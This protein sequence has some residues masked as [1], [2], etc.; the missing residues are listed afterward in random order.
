M[1][2]K[3]S[4]PKK[5]LDKQYSFSPTLHSLPPPSSSL[6]YEIRLTHLFSMRF[7]STP[8]K[9]QKTL[10]FSDIFRFKRK[11]ALRT[12]HE[13]TNYIDSTISNGKLRKLNAVLSE[14]SVWRFL[15]ALNVTL[16]S[17]FL[18]LFWIWLH[19]NFKFIL[20]RNQS[21][22]PYGSRNIY[23]MHFMYKSNC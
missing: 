4:L 21:N 13:R 1:N 6:L 19:F 18:I 14:E 9:H 12:I 17:T 22:F 7:F 16:L 8:W 23:L 3:K 11:D 20:S 5:P 15:N 10:R 2:G